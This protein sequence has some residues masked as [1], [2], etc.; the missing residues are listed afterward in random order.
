[1]ERRSF[2]WNIGFDDIE[3]RENEAGDPIGFSGYFARFNDLSEDLGGFVEKIQ[4]GAFSKT[5]KESDIRFLLNHDANIV[6]GRNTAGTL[7]LRER[8]AGLWFENDLPDTTQARDLMVN[9]KAGN[10][11]QGSFGFQT[12]RD[13]WKEDAEPIVRTLQEVKLIDVSLVTFPAYPSTSVSARFSTVA[14]ALATAGEK[15]GE[16]NRAE[17]RALSTHAEEL[18]QYLSVEPPSRHSAD[19]DVSTPPDWGSRLKRRWLELA[20]R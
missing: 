3:I 9:V 14:E 13:K 11:T 18:Q 16:L 19:G 6:L 12:V 17:L 2:S 10:I 7:R 1:M 15:D 4:R 5:I 20:A 8:S